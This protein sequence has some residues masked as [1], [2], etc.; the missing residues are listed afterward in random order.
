MTDSIYILRR[1]GT[2]LDNHGQPLNRAFNANRLV[3]RSTDEL[4]GLC[5]GLTI[6]GAI[7]EEEVQCLRQWLETY[8]AAADAWPGNVIRARVDRILEDGL[9]TQEERTDLF[10]LLREVVGEKAEAP[11]RDQSTALPL[12][13][14]APPIIFSN[15]TFCLTG[16]FAWGVSCTV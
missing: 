6:D 15:N 4:I 13:K 7:S 5:R 1:T 2:A 3:E 10:E 11:A 8:R 9:I 14:P 16:R 12:S